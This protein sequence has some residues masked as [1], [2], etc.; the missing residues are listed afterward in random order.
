MS[1][2]ADQQEGGFP[3]R[4]AQFMMRMRWPVLMTVL[5]ATLLAAIQIPKVDI[6]HHHTRSRFSQP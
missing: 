4:Y 1:K 2:A 5:I 6:R 3:L